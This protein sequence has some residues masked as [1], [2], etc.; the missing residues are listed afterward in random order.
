MAATKAPPAPTQSPTELRVLERFF[1]VRNA[2]IEL[3]LTDPNEAD[4]TTGQRWLRDGFN[5][6]A[7]GSKGHKFPGLYMGRELMF[8]ESDLA[9]I[10]RIAR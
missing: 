3:G 8:S 6:P 4:D 10:T 9:E 1:N 5:R 7:D 2:A